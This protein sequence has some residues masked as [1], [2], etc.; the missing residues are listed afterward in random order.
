MVLLDSPVTL[1]TSANL[2]NR[3]CFIVASYVCHSEAAEHLA[4]T[5]V[6]I[7]A[8]RVVSLLRYISS[9]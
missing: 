8:F 2:I 9:E 4:K 5:G 6:K 7:S 3:C 1:L